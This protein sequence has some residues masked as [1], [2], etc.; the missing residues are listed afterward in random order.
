MDDSKVKVKV[1]VKVKKPAK[2]EHT[3][4]SAPTSTPTVITKK[5]PGAKTESTDDSSDAKV[6]VTVKAPVQQRAPGNLW[7]GLSEVE[8]KLV[9]GSRSNNT[10][11]LEALKEGVNPNL[12][13]EQGRTV[14]H[15]VA[16]SGSSIAMVLLIH[17]GAQLNVKDNQGLTPMHMAAGYAK[18]RSLSVL[19]AA[20]ADPNIE[21]PSQGTPLKIVTDLGQYQL[22]TFMNRK[23]AEKITKKKDDRLEA[24]KDCL[25]AFDQAEKIKADVEWD[26]WVKEVLQ[27]ITGIKKKEKS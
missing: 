5:P 7:Q 9:D 3:D 10:L 11:L 24:L 18:A 17:F 27:V 14:L 25:V 15:Y 2:P 26:E 23:G 20:G 16:A 21:A 1:K 8:Q 6:K 19:I 13:D 22:N 12:V 4:E